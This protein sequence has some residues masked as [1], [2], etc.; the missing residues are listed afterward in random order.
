V[1]SRRWL[2]A[3]GHRLAPNVHLLLVIKE[4]RNRA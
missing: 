2:F 4:P 3:A 1:R